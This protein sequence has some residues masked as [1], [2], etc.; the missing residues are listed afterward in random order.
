MGFSEFDMSGQPASVTQRAPPDGK[1]N[2][3]Q[4]HV[5]RPSLSAPTGEAYRRRPGDRSIRD[6]SRKNG[7]CTPL[8][9]TPT[10]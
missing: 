3:V 2:L 1:D 8:R 9:V 4:L 10:S 7:A 5:D 6:L